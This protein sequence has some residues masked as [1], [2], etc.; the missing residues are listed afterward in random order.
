MTGPILSLFRSPRHTD[1]GC[2]LAPTRALAADERRHMEAAPV[3]LARPVLVLSG[4]RSPYW[5]G[6]GLARRLE[7]LTC[8]DASRFRSV[9]YMLSWS[10]EGAAQRAVE[11]V[12][13]AWP[14]AAHDD[15]TEVD[16]V[17]VSMGGLVA[18]AG[19]AG[20]GGSRRL[21]IHRLFTLA[22]PH[23]GAALAERI[24][25][26]LAAREMRPGSEW[27]A[28]LDAALPDAAAEIIPYARTGDAWVGATRTAPPGRDPI[29]TRGP[30][31][32][33]HFTIA[34]DEAITLDIA[35]RLRGESPLAT[36]A[37]PPPC[38]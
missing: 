11:A 30:F 35:R 5:Q 1:P 29:W 32:L 34:L 25:P 23:R 3:A 20:L 4:W 6:R 22:T 33:S 12:Q 38:D 26:D 8:R 15:T 36:G 13:A 24:R 18:R 21:R 10:I 9:S 2:P 16:V 27:L 7:A 14:S 31:C 28:R 37:S 19:A 17:A